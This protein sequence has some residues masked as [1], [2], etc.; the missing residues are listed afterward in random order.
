MGG[1]RTHCGRLKR[2]TISGAET[3]MINR[4]IRADF[5]V[6]YC[7]EAVVRHI[8][9]PERRTKKFLINRIK[10]DGATQPL[11]DLDRKEF[12]DVNIYRRI[13]YDARQMVKYFIKSFGYYLLKNEKQGFIQYLY[14]IQKWGRTEMEM[15]FLYDKEFSPVW[16]QRHSR[17]GN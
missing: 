5:P 7:P 15:K 12:R 17:F 16:K 9:V 6:F 8:V 14:A 10:G 11:L 1:F 3:E 4:I 13:L 2:R